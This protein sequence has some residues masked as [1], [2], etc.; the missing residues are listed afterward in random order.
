[1]DASS[2]NP[3]WAQPQ[4]ASPES[5][6]Y[7]QI[8]QGGAP[9]TGTNI[10]SASP[11][12]NFPPAQLTSSGY[13]LQIK[14]KNVTDPFA[15]YD[16]N[17]MLTREP[18]PAYSDIEK[19]PAEPRPRTSDHEVVELHEG[20]AIADQPQALQTM[21]KMVTMLNF[22]KVITNTSTLAKV[23]LVWNY[24]KMQNNEKTIQFSKSH[25]TT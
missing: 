22:M 6:G 17:N 12:Q 8:I 13:E 15:P 20:G 11:Q 5:G 14:K 9:R 4:K 7:S 3:I 19:H 21:V 23:Y 2:S 16:M 18:P 25:Q 24:V 10:A 1:L